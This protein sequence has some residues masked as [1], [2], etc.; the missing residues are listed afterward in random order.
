MTTLTDPDNISLSRYE[1]TKLAPPLTDAQTEQ[2]FSNLNKPDYTKVYPAVERRYADPPIP[3]QK[4]GLFS[5]VPAKGAIPNDKGIFGF[6]KLRGNYA[7]EREADTE[8][9]KLIRNVDSYHQI[10]HTFVGRHFPCT[11]SSDFSKTVSRVDIRKEMSESIAEDIKKKRE[12]E[13][14]EIE[15]IKNKEKELLEDVKKTEDENKD[16]NYTTM[17]TKWAQ[18]AWTYLETEKKMKQMATILAKTR[19]EIEE[20]ET[21]HPEVKET[22]FE[23]YVEAR[24]KAGL[25][26]DKDSLENTFMKYLVEDV[27]I[28]AVEAEYELLYGKGS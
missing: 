26:V 9:E 1:E 14:Q 6:A 17:R 3:M 25:S 16:D 24:K 28:P 7:T 10:F 13:Q 23:R 27:R 8:A 11:T 20:M 5:F 15:E 12:K 21:K 2:A 19:K 18:V 4:I 22:Y